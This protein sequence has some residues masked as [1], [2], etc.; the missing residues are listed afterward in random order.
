MGKC[1]EVFD[2][3]V[4]EQEIVQLIARGC[5]DTVEQ[6]MYYTKEELQNKFG[7]SLE[8]AAEMLRFLSNELIVRTTALPQ[9]PEILTGVPALDS[10]FGGG[11]PVGQLVEFY[12]DPGAGKS[13]LAM[14]L[15]FQ[16]QLSE[17]FG[18][19]DGS[20][21]YISTGG[22]F[23]IKRLEQLYMG[24]ASKQ[25]TPPSLSEML[26][27]I[28]ILHIR[29]LETQL[30]ILKY[31]V[32]SFIH[33]HNIKLLVL[34]SIA[35]NFRGME[36]GGSDDIIKR[37]G[38]IYETGQVL[39]ELASKCEMIV[40]CVNEVSAQFPK[41]TFVGAFGQGRVYETQ[42]SEWERSKVVPALGNALSVCI[43]TRVRFEKN[44]DRRTMHMVFSPY[45]PNSQI[46]FV[47]EADGIR[48][49]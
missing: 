42:E 13:C 5:V 29:D 6:I 8:I 12:G 20:A 16:V 18:G 47:V 21:L 48:V 24:F 31:Q 15:C 17:S 28:H 3:D 26:D 27:H 9:R 14:Q 30:H 25:S 35:P 22:R 23:P 40:I 38:Y 37:A 19:L 36:D 46:D 33:R 49:L 2:F 7:V 45:A 10:F 39:S 32:P 34:D 43:N 11:I 41:S 44:S 4:M 1:Q